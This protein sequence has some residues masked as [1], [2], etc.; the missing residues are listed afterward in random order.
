[1]SQ[2]TLGQKCGCS[3]QNR[4]SRSRCVHPPL[5]EDHLLWRDV[6][7]EIVESDLHGSFP[8]RPVRLH[9]PENLGKVKIHAVKIDEYMLAPV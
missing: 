7:G 3:I 6:A 2:E 9:G 8:E 5:A 1:M 4:T